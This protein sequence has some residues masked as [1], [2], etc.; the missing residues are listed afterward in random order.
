MTLLATPTC[1]ISSLPG[2]LTNFLGEPKGNAFCFLTLGEPDGLSGESGRLLTA[3]NIEGR[4]LLAAAFV[5]DDAPE[6]FKE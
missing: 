2:S 4:E 3:G 5:L 6:K 1:G